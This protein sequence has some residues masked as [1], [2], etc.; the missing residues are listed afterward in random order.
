MQIQQAK[1]HF[2]FPCQ[3]MNANEW[4]S[5]KWHLVLQLDHFVLLKCAS[6]TI[7]VTVAVLINVPFE[8]TFL[9]TFF[10]STKIDNLK[11]TITFSK[12]IMKSTL[13]VFLLSTIIS[14]TITKSSSSS[15]SWPR[16]PLPESIMNEVYFMN[17]KEIDW[18][19][20]EI[21]PPK[22]QAIL[23][24]LSSLLHQLKKT[25]KLK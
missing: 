17:S 7:I 5:I 13:T 20:V 16:D 1:N 2:R 8:L 22:Q 6:T 18:Q 3:W 9:S 23:E 24:R 15:V 4:K 14:T 25:N 19:P 10:I 21:R 11:V 12:S